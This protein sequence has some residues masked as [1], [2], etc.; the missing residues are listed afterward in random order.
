MIKSVNVMAANCSRLSTHWVSFQHQNMLP[1]HSCNKDLANDFGEFFKRKVKRLLDRLDN[2]N[3]PELSVDLS[4]TC[5]SEFPAFHEVSAEDVSQIL[6]KSSVKSC[7]LDPLLARLLKKCLDPLLPQL[8][9]LHH[10]FVTLVWRF[11]FFFFVNLWRRPSHTPH[12]R[13]A[14]ADWNELKNYRPISNLQ[15]VSKTT[16]RVLAAQ[17]SEYLVT[18]NLYAPN[19]SAYRKFHSTETAL[20]RIQNDILNAVDQHLE[21]VL[22]LLDFSAAFDTLSYPALL[23]RLCESYGIT[24]TALKQYKSYLQG[25]SQSVVINEEMSDTFDLDEGV[26]QGSVNGPLIYV[27]ALLSPHRWCYQCS[28]YQVQYVCWCTTECHQHVQLSVN[29][30]YADDTQLYMLLHPSER[31]FVIPILEVCLRDIKAWTTRNRL[32]LNDSK[33]RGGSHKLK[34]RGNTIL[35][36]DNLWFNWSWGIARCKESRRHLR[37][38]YGHERSC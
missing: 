30:T 7:P 21:A 12:K 32:V 26:P 6:M 17:L 33:K 29:S 9:S 35:P 31:D 15:F 4:D 36:K 16:E 38:I 11:F 23:Q 19:Q 37:W 1:D 22:L 8:T 2:I 13:G 10:H 34:I 28:R 24:G 3:P 5:E 18:N 14:N 27:H 20:V 25:R